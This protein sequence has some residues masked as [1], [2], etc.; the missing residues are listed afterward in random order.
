M[1]TLAAWPVL[2]AVWTALRASPLLWAAVAGA[3]ALG[4]ASLKVRSIVH[5]RNVAREATEIE[6]AAAEVRRLRAERAILAAAARRG[7]QLAAERAADIERQSHAIADL[8]EQLSHARAE[9]TVDPRMPV[10][11][12]DDPWLRGG[13]AAAARDPRAR[14]R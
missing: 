5:D 11:G 13:A 4:A 2:A 1:I 10:V 14:R 7:E 12:A 3:I 8:E 9:T 6:R